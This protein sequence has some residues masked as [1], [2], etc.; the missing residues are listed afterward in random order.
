M[1]TTVSQH[2]SVPLGYW[3]VYMMESVSANEGSTLRY[4][5][6]MRLV[7]QLA[8]SRVTPS[9][10]V[11]VQIFNFWQTLISKCEGHTSKHAQI[12]LT[13]CLV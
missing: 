7:L 6:S 1:Y 12:C 2:T 8:S 10:T 13:K 5:T 11:E 3:Q 9:P 4:V